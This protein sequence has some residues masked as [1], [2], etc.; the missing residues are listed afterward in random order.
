ML[1]YINLRILCDV[2]FIVFLIS[3][4][5][6][7]H[8]LA[9]IVIKSLVV[10]SVHLVPEMWAPERSNYY[11]PLVHKTLSILLVSIEVS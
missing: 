1:R 4:I 8:V 3:W 6:T 11:S 2:T 10:D 7:R 9:V 5:I